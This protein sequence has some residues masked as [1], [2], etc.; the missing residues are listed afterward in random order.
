MTLDK[1]RPRDITDFFSNKKTKI[2]EEI[3]TTKTE[4]E[5]KSSFKTIPIINNK[6]SFKDEYVGKLTPKQ[7]QLLQLEIDTMEDSWF[8]ALKDEFTKE[9]FLDL[10]RFLL[11]EW[12]SGTTIFPPQTDIYSW[13][14]LTPIKDVKVLIIGQDPYHNYKQAHGLAFSVKDP[15]TKPPPSLINIFKG[16]T[17]DYPN[18]KTPNQGDLTLWAKQGVLLLNTVLT[19]RAHQANSHA[20]KGWEKFTRQVL[21]I[22]LE[23]GQGIVII[24]WGKPAEKLAKEFDNSINKNKNCFLYGVHPSPLSAYR[25]QGFFTQGHF[26]ECNKW[27]EDNKRE[28]VKWDVL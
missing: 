24:A 3:K 10:K 28:I 12:K 27:L 9:Y 23:K 16:V 7:R 18:F 21:K 19:V 25:G 5:T 8:E 13:T 26:L 6:R 20:K 2:I 11:T 4:T 1:K 22:L 14:R 17:V 15:K